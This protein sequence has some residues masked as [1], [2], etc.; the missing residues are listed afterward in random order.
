MTITLAP[1]RPRRALAGIVSAAV[2]LALVVGTP[3]AQA[4]QSAPSGAATT[5]ADPAATLT[6]KVS[7]QFVDHFSPSAWANSTLVADQGATLDADKA[8]VFAEGSGWADPASGDSQV[9]YE[10]RVTGTFVAGGATQ[11]S[12]AVAD[13]V[14]AV[15]DGHGTVTAD[16]SYS[17]PRDS[18]E[19]T[20]E[21]VV[22]TTFDADAGDWD[23]RTLS[24]TP[25]WD[26]VLPAGS[27][28]AT[29]LGLP[30]DQPIEGRSFAP[31]LLEALPSS[32]RAHFY[33]SGSGSDPKKAPAPLTAAAPAPQLTA[34]VTSADSAGLQVHVTGNGYAPTN[35]GIYVGITEAGPIVPRDATAYHGT[36]W[37]P[38]SAIS[39]DGTFDEDLELIA[40]DEIA[41][42]D[43]DAEYEVHTQKAHGLSEGDPSQNVRLP[44]DID[45]STWQQQAPE[46][47]IAT[48]ET[49]YGKGGTIV[50]SSP[51]TRGRVSLSLDGS[52]RTLWFRDGEA[53]FAVPK[54]LTARYYTLR[55][56]YHGNATTPGA[57]ASGRL[58]VRSAGTVTDGRVTTIPRT[59]RRGKIAVVVRNG[60]N[61]SPVPRGTVTVR[62]TRFGK[63]V[64]ETRTLVW[65][66]VNITLPPMSWGTWSTTV[67]YNGQPTKY[68]RS[69][70]RTSFKVT[71]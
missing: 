63:T 1:R 21:D 14:V 61:T 39:A 11:Y 8:T 69:S 38:A 52:T 71:R 64:T 20:V 55:A 70:D 16:V 46:L 15:E 6:W 32:L 42:L 58:I 13:P 50:V 44:L 43:Q 3:A 57:T 53:R 29:A 49:S 31:E 47:S 7:Q 22:L 5:A 45:F 34:E 4:T 19:G 40:P 59:D 51:G 41:E 2:P 12:V 25:D 60:S 37:L 27:A 10:G 23:D 66:K 17:V 67:T 68:L 28:E 9:S 24:A 36:I 26:G 48:V 54:D 35:P 56:T 62:M 30:A 33:S 65:G 18:S